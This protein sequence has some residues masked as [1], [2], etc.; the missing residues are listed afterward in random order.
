MMNKLLLRLRQASQ[1]SLVFELKAICVLITMSQIPQSNEQLMIC[2]SRFQMDFTNH[3][4]KLGYLIDFY[5]TYQITHNFNHCCYPHSIGNSIEFVGF[6]R[7]S[8]EKKR[9]STITL[10]RYSKVLAHLNFITKFIKISS[11]FE[12]HHLILMI[13]SPNDQ[14]QVKQLRK[15]YPRAEL[16]PFQLF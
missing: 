9:Y 13:L 1:K 16:A 14:N 10:A 11:K 4:K 3:C 8:F 2:E 12:N 5:A 7:I 15:L 6:I